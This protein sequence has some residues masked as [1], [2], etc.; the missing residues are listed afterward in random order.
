[1]SAEHYDL[2]IIGAGIV[3]VCLA[4]DATAA[5]MRTVL[6]DANAPGLGASA[7][8]MGHLVALGSDE[9][10]LR[11]C[12]LGQRRWREYGDLPRAQWSDAGTLW[13]AAD[14][15]EIAPLQERSK[16]LSRLGISSEWLDTQALNEAE[17]GL[18]PRLPGALRV[19]DDALIYPPG[20]L[21]DLLQ[22]AQ[23]AGLKLRSGH[24]VSELRESDMQLSDGSR[25]AAG[26]RVVCCGLHSAQLLP[27]LPLIPRRGQLA[28]TDR[29]L[30]APRHALVEAGYVATTQSGVGVACNIQPRP[31]GQLLIG[32]S[33]EASSETTLNPALLGRMLKR[34][35]DFY[36][37]LAQLPV[38]R[39]WSGIRPSS[40]D[41]HPFI[42]AWPALKQTWVA[43]GHEGLGI[44]TAPATASLLMDMLLGRTSELDVAAYDPARALI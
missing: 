19:T 29:G 31:G 25:I 13:I 4:V 23:Q 18:R 14:E 34:A 10:E 21:L 37:V 9:H 1:V 22:R 43:A 17:P 41:G 32:A 5:G 28:I 39:C 40:A 11:L 36:P 2:A 24:A 27:G 30:H 44:T 20:A 33:R 8:A 15:A 42:G 6:I 26:Q 38:I 35:I 3:G 12:Q 16:Q 7:A